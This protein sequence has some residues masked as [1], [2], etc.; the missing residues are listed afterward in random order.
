MP[1]LSAT[2]RPYTLH[3]D[4]LAINTGRKTDQLLSGFQRAVFFLS[5]TY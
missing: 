1:V 5:E 2:D 3:Y 4:N